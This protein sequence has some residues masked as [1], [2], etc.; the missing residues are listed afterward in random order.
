[1]TRSAHTTSGSYWDD[2]LANLDELAGFWL[3][4]AVTGRDQ[5][6]WTHMVETSR[7]SWIQRAEGRRDFIPSPEHHNEEVHHAAVLPMPDPE[8]PARYLL[9][10]GEEFRAGPAAMQNMAKKLLKHGWRLT[11]CSYC[12]GPW[13]KKTETVKVTEENE[14][15]KLIETGVEEKVKYDQADSYV[16][17]FRRGDLVG[18][19]MWLYR[20]WLKDAKVSFYTAHVLPYHG[21]V[22][23]TQ[24]KPIIE[25]P[26]HPTPLLKEI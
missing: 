8:I 12:R 4:E 9:L 23:S 13:P 20:P 15:G 14:D 26:E 3:F 5:Q 10:N 7:L 16:L 21:K 18:W 17:R 1:M 25:N 22:N 19:A 6:N 24:L 2:V 11:G